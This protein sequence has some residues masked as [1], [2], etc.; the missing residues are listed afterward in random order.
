MPAIG[1]N[2]DSTEE[3]YDSNVIIAFKDTINK[4]QGYSFKHIRK[5]G[6]KGMGSK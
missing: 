2:I 5:K 1:I 6:C 3:M 4:I